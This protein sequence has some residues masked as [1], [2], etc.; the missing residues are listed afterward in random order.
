MFVGRERSEEEKDKKTYEKG[1]K[2]KTN[3]DTKKEKSGD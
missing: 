1:E 3:E 2:I